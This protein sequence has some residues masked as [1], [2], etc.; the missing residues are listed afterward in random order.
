MAIF[1]TNILWKNCTLYIK[2]KIKQ[3]KVK[4]KQKRA[5][6]GPFKIYKKQQ[7]KQCVTSRYYYITDLFSFINNNLWRCPR[8]LRL[9]FA[10]QAHPLPFPGLETAS[11]IILTFLAGK[12]FFKAHLFEFVCLVEQLSGWKVWHKHRWAHK[13]QN[14]G[15]GFVCKFIG[16]PIIKCHLTTLDLFLR[17]CP[18][19]GNF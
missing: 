10:C 13:S 14:L 6:D 11:R 2:V 15:W 18:H 7:I 3:K 19:I 1:S 17:P 16:T 8:C 5:D 9:Q 12:R 4:I